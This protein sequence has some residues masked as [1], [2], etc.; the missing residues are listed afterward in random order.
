M[1]R[2]R[3][4][5]R[6]MSEMKRDTIIGLSLRETSPVCVLQHS[7]NAKLVILTFPTENKTKKYLKMLSCNCCDFVISALKITATSPLFM[8]RPLLPSTKQAREVTFTWAWCGG[9]CMLKNEISCFLTGMYAAAWNYPGPCAP[10]SIRRPHCNKDGGEDTPPP[11]FS[12]SLPA[13]TPSWGMVGH[14]D[15]F[16]QQGDLC[17]ASGQRGRYYG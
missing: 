8:N 5:R 6:W 12:L 1:E 11:N 16:T 3:M 9:R 14:L 7:I 10:S 17:P 15:D 4:N 2:V 13:C